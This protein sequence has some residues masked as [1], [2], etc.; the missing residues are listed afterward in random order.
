MEDVIAYE[1]HIQDFTDLLPVED[2]F[3]GTFNAMVTPGLKNSQGQKIGFDYL[4]DLGINTVHLMPVQE[5]LHFPDD[6][7]K[8]SFKDDPYMIEQGISEENYQWGYRTSHCFC[9]GIKI[10][11]KG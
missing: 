5:Y 11:I 9:C 6:D 8:S 1:V 7:W 3:K 2:K 10:P 4:V